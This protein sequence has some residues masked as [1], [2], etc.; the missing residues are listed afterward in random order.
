MPRTP[1]PL[2]ARLWDKIDQSGGPTACWPWTGAITVSRS[3]KNRSTSKYGAIREGG[4]GSKMWR[5]HRLILLIW[6]CPE[7][8]WGAELLKWIH[9]ADRHYGDLQA[10]HQCDFNLCCNPLHLQWETHAENL[11]N[12]ARR[13]AEREE[14]VA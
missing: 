1:T 8:A 14:A 5:A 12:Q 2:L 7:E 11:E 9:T 4:R 3:R 6:S 13:T 10:A